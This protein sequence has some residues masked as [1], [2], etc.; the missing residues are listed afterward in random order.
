MSTPAEQIWVCKIGGNVRVPNGGD[1]QMR[2]AVEAAFKALTGEPSAFLFSGWAGRLAELERAV[3]ENR[4]PC[5]LFCDDWHVINA[6]TTH[7]QHNGVL[8]EA[9]MTFG[10]RRAAGDTVAQAAAFARREWDF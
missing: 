5:D 2:T 7:A 10:A 4:E 6:L 8:I 3:H 1:A 9:V